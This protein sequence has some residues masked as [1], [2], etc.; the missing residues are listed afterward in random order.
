MTATVAPP[1]PV[2][3]PP[4]TPPATDLPDPGW[5]IIPGQ[6]I[7]DPPQTAL[8]IGDPGSGKSYAACTYPG[9]VA[10]FDTETRADS[11]AK[12]FRNIFVKHVRTFEEI[13]GGIAWL[14]KKYP[15]GGGTIVFDSGSD[16]RDM[17]E[18]YVVAEMNRAK[19]KVHPTL[20]WGRVYDELANMLAAL[21]KRGWNVVFTARLGDVY[22]NDRKTG[23][24][25]A[26]G[27]IVN[28]VMYHADF[29]VHL[30]K[31]EQQGCIV[32]D[33]LKDASR[34]VGT[35]RTLLGPNEL[36]FAGFK[37]FLAEPEKAFTWDANAVKPIQ[38]APATF[39]PGLAPIGFTATAE[40][41]AKLAADLQA[42]IAADKAKKDAANA[43]PAGGL[44]FAAPGAGDWKMSDSQYNELGKLGSQAKLTDEEKASVPA[45]ICGR[46]ITH[47]SD[48]THDEYD[49]MCAKLLEM[50]QQREAIGNGPKM[51][52]LVKAATASKWD[53]ARTLAYAQ[54]LTDRPDLGSLADLTGTQADG[55]IAGLRTNAKLAAAKEA[56]A[57]EAKRAAKHLPA[58]PLSMQSVMDDLLHDLDLPPMPED[59]NF[60]PTGEAKEPI[61][62]LDGH[63]GV[64][65]SEE[66]AI[67]G[68][69]AAHWA[70][71]FRY[72]AEKAFQREA[73]T[74]NPAGVPDP[75]EKE[76]Q[77][78]GRKLLN[79]LSLAGYFL[80]PGMAFPDT[81]YRV[82]RVFDELIGDRAAAWQQVIGRKLAERPRVLTEAN[83]KALMA[84]L[85]APLRA[86]REKKKQ[87]Q[88]QAGAA[89]AP[90][91]K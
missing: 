88:Q 82:E 59:Y 79:K 28:K 78:I 57:A 41:G 12:R 75:D 49:R 19:T 80:K 74:G 24:R 72:E 44:P 68:K 31:D 52:E 4:A 33:V 15:K 76:L 53:Q 29:V 27:F 40:S 69:I 58:P 10:I 39:T 42:R 81:V 37:A 73:A 48:L 64:N 50:K 51:E 89:S 65:E 16:L 87:V 55:L 91:A 46:P 36:T 83:A 66:R 14:W 77:E 45:A 54:K 22:E 32:G 47:F 18:E 26:A 90:A 3:A 9:P 86:L 13:V 5:D 34:R 60:L 71:T 1:A 85:A 62:D 21:R 20:H 11:L 84:S 35:Y 17:I 56:H 6:E 8:L 30:K 43:P 7:P 2:A 23:K 63:R 38:P 70:Y 61:T 25:E 67:A